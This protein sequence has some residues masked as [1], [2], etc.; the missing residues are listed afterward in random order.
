MIS[1]AKPCPGA[2]GSFR[3][4]QAAGW[5]RSSGATT[6]SSIAV[7]RSRCCSR[8]SPPS[9]IS[10]ARFK[11]EARSAARLNHP[12]IVSVHDWGAED[13]RTYYM[14]MEYV[15]GTDLREVLTLRGP[16]APGQAID[17]VA[18]VCEALGVAHA[19]GLVHRDIK[20]ENILIARDGTVKVTDFGIAA[21]ADVDL[22]MPGG[23][24][25]GTIRYMA[26]EQARGDEATYAS[27]VWAAG[28]LLFELLTGEPLFE[29]GGLETLQL[30]AFEQPRRPSEV[31]AGIPAVIDPLVT[32]ACDPDPIKR[33]ERRARD[34]PRA[35]PCSG[36]V[37][38]SVEFT[39]RQCDR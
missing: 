24:I 38:R 20:P 6:S 34:G 7:L 31:D 21:V 5:V 26:P 39:A 29:G 3:A 35:T 18:G 14:V 36:F 17:I 33:Y 12:N 16:V 32:T 9:P 27:D 37:G 10:F 19:A 13:D 11:Q 15:S 22:T 30:R 23:T 2:T 1:L 4:W 28:A 25:P 8:H